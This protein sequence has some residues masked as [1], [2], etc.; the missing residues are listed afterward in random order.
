M[1][2]F[3]YDFGKALVIVLVIL[4]ITRWLLRKQHPASTPKTWWRKDSEE[5]TPDTHTHHRPF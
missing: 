3:S 2:D 5:K 4:P 1:H